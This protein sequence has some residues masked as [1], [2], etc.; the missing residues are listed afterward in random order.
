MGNLIWVVVEVLIVI[1]EYGSVGFVFVFGF[2]VINI[3][4]LLFL[5]GDYIIVGNDV[6]GGIFCLI[7][8]VLKYFG[9]IFIVVDM[10]DLVVVEVVII[11]II[12]VIY[13]EILMNLLLYIM[14]IVVIVKFV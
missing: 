2:V 4:F 13:L 1:F 5:V 6:Y 14:D 8:V 3:V 7:D 9:M 10:C 12:K 11:F